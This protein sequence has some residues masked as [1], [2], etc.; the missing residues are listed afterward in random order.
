MRFLGILIVL[1]GCPSGPG[2]HDPD[3]STDGMPHAPGMFVDW[4]ANP[5]LPGALNDK[6]TVTEVS[7][8]VSHFQVV[9]DGGGDA[10][11]TR[12]G[13]QLE[14]GSASAPGQEKFPD[15]PAGVY[16]KIFLD[17]NSGRDVPHA[18]EIRG[19]WRD[20][21]TNRPFRIEDDRRLTV[22]IDCSKMLVG[23]AATVFAIR[24]DLRNAVTGVDFTKFENDDGVLELKGGSELEKFRSTL[25]GS[26]F[27]VDN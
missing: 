13:Y 27:K 22:S 8:G 10:R 17:L 1:A 24:V 19:V 6:I 4:N 7:F 14:W 26:A 21:S 20:Q 25:S 12:G 5:A 3:A 9:G 15:A 23:G 2:A 11:T 16:S 18:F